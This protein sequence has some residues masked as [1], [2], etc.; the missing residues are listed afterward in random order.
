[1]KDPQ[2]FP[3]YEEILSKKQ[4]L[5]EKLISINK[6]NLEEEM[7]IDTQKPEHGDVNEDIAKFLQQYLLN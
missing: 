2:K 7:E 1:M 6:I 5:Y 3:I 4:G